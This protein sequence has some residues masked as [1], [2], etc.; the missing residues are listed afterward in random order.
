[1]FNSSSSSRP[2]RD[3]SHAL[4]Q[5]LSQMSIHQ[6][7]AASPSFSSPPVSREFGSGNTLNYI[8]S[9]NFNGSVAEFNDYSTLNR[10]RK[11]LQIQERIVEEEKRLVE[12]QKRIVETHRR[13]QI[14]RDKL[15]EE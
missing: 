13:L 4:P 2:T 8:P 12:E 6:E 1:M 15:L 3:V 5:M 14:L 10:E 11:R 9:H 7:H